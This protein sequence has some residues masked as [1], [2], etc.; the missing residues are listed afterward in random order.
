MSTPTPEE[1]NAE[2]HA[3][4]AAALT[5]ATTEL[6]FRVELLNKM[7]SSCHNKCAAKPP[8][9]G[10]LSVGE[11]SCIDRCCSKYWQVVAIVGQ[12]LGTSK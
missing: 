3:M 10:S 6:E 7:V 9:E 12:L 11:N 2:N 5:L 4:A 8:K 1:I